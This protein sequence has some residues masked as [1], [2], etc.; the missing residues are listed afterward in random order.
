M[1][2]RW[3]KSDYWFLW[4][5]A[6]AVILGVVLTIA[7]VVDHESGTLTVAHVAVIA[8]SILV[9]GGLIWLLHAA[10]ISSVRDQIRFALVPRYTCLECGYSF[11]GLRHDAHGLV[12]CSE[13][14]LLARSA[15]SD[16][17]IGSA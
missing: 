5:C 15:I 1:S 16:E 9:G 6:G 10:S 4:A 17:P 12:R 11:A 8:L 14:G 13:C 7:I 3:F 2:R